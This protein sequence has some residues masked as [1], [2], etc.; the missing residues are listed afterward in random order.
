MSAGKESAC[1]AGDPGLVA[2]LGRSPGEGIGY[3]VHYS[4]KKKTKLYVYS[5]TFMHQHLTMHLSSQ[6]IHFLFT[7]SFS[8]MKISVLSQNTKMHQFKNKDESL[9][10]KNQFECSGVNCIIA[11]IHTCQKS[12]ISLKQK[13]KPTDLKTISVSEYPTIFFFPLWLIIS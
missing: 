1:N 13:T 3:P 10:F 5:I 8:C 2:W 11:A 6:M 12:L 9:V 7:K 4:W